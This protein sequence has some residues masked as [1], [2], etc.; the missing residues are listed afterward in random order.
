MTEVLRG[1]SGSLQKNS[2]TV[3]EIRERPLLCRSP[4][5]AA[6]LETVTDSDLKYPTNI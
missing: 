1:T 5:D 6:G 3:N 2:V 4:F